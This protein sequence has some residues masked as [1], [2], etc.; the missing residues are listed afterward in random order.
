MRIIMSLAFSLAVVAC[1]PGV[2]VAGGPERAPPGQDT[3]GAAAFQGLVGR[4]RSAILP[5]PRDRVQ[6]VHARGEVLTMDFS[7]TRLNIEYDRVSGRIL[8]VYCG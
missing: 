3:C 6:R 8:R 4:P 5:A 7:E 2:P 1:A